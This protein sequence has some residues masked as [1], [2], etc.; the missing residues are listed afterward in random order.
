M[1]DREQIENWG[2]APRIMYV[3]STPAGGWM[4]ANAGDWPSPGNPSDTRYL[5][6]DIAE[7]EKAAAVREAVEA[8][9]DRC[10]SHVYGQCSSD[11]VA[12]RTVAKIRKGGEQ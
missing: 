8:E 9:R 6:A 11:N 5:R 12:Q 3:A 2:E 4:N 7:A 1:N 10:I